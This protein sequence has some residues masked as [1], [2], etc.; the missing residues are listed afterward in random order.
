MF[1]KD[2]LWGT[3]I[4]SYQT[5]GNNFNSDWWEWEQRGKTKDKSG[6]A[7]DYW[8]Q[9]EKYHDLVQELGCNAFRLSLEW[10]RIEPE[11]G[12]FSDEA[13]GR[14]RDILEDLKKRNIKTVV[15]FWHW[16]SPIWFQKKY[17]FQNKKS[18]DVFFQYGKKVFNELGDLIDFVVVIN[19]PMMPLSFGYL[20]GKFP[21]GKKNIFE[22]FR[23]FDNLSK[24]YKNIFYYI[25]GKKEALP[26]GITQ[27]Y[28]F[29][30][31]KR[32]N[33]PIS[34]FSAWIYKGFWNYSFLEKIKKELDYI[35][36]D[37]YF[38]DRINYF[39]RD[40]DNEKKN[41]LGWEIYPEGIYQVAKE[42]KEK[43]HLPIYIMENGLA[44]KNDKFR[45]QFINDHLQFLSKAIEEGVD[46]RGYFHWS[47]CDNFEWLHGFEPRFGLV[48]IDYRTLERKPRRSFYEYKK[49]I[50]ENKL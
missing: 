27:L 28:N 10:S 5:E 9:Y 40:N 35:G 13:I 22:Y 29:I 25:K 4:S 26:V 18:I 34:F 15:T 17:G 44:D 2:F 49:I 46:I 47:L 14:Y 16:T 32:K 24:S 48:E 12:K 30:E 41:D 39:F 33:N 7:C 21:P 11:E 45:H 8:N 31:P 6:I 43:Y 19:E 20:L 42:L 23:A 50:E 38:H 36:L 3:A 37:Y 1:P